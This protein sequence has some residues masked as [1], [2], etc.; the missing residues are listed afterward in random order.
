MYWTSAVFFETVTCSFLC[1][2][3]SQAE[4]IQSDTQIAIDYKPLPDMLP[5]PRLIH[6]HFFI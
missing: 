2:E 6:I 5:L 3:V 1:A 4:I